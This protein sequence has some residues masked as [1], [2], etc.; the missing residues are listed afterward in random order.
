M[1]SLEIGGIRFPPT[2]LFGTTIYIDGPE[3]EAQKL[4]HKARSSFLPLCYTSHYIYGLALAKV[5]GVGVYRRVGA[6]EILLRETYHINETSDFGYVEIDQ[7]LESALLSLDPTVRDVEDDQGSTDEM[8][9]DMV[10]L[11]L[12]HLIQ[13]Q[14]HMQIFIQ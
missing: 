2:E 12:L 6:V 11:K 4:V 7:Q 5:R 1:P 13:N 14:K 9:W 8:K 3:D 10:A